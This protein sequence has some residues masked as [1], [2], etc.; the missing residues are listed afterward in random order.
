[1]LPGWEVANVAGVPVLEGVSHVYNFTAFN[2]ELFQQIEFVPC[3][4][5]L[6][7]LR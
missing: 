2:V 7:D 6:H 4:G 1:M 3:Y 5:L